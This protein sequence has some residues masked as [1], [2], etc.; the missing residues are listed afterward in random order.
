MPWEICA[1]EEDVLNQSRGK[2]KY[3]PVLK[4]LKQLCWRKAETKLTAMTLF[5]SDR[6]EA[7]I[8]VSLLCGVFP[9]GR[10]EFCT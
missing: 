1:K 6:Q 8:L 10:Q 4:F 7:G 2:E 9:V 3:I 5:F